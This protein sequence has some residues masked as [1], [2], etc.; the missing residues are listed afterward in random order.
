M[1]KRGKYRK[2]VANALIAFLLTVLVNFSYLV[3]L[4]MS[5]TEAPQASEPTPPRTEQMVT[6]VAQDEVAKGFIL[7]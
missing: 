2:I 1:L 4:M 7:R 5:R 3:F 6:E